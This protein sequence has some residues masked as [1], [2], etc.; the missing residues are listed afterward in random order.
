MRGLRFALLLTGVW[1]APPA[2]ADAAKTVAFPDK[3][4]SVVVPAN[5]PLHLN[6]FDQQG[7]DAASF[8][9]KMLL[10]G[11]FYLSNNMDLMLEPDRVTLSQLPHLKHHG[12]GEAFKIQLSNG[13]AFGH[14]ALT[15]AALADAKKK[16]DDEYASGKVGIWADHFHL[17]LACGEA[18]I[19]A[20]YV[21]VA[22]PPGTIATATYE[23]GDC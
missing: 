20:N 15:A 12:W 23:G 18:M 1:L 2:F 8:D 10:S 22:T 6:A 14:A 9:G 17:R 5:S 4:D 19:D 3:A 7:S 16:G 13:A 21:S 11:K